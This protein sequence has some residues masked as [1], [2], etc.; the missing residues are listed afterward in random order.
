MT[1]IEAWN[2]VHQL[3][4]AAPVIGDVGDARDE[5]LDVLK[6]LAEAAEK[7]KPKRQ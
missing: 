4:R 7:P 2:V 6:G 5:A 3:A 1:P